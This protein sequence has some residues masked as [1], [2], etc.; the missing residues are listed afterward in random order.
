MEGLGC[1]K[2][3]HCPPQCF[4]NVPFREILKTPQTLTRDGL[5]GNL[6]D[7]SPLKE[8]EIRRLSGPFQALSKSMGE[9]TTSG[10]EVDLRIGV[11]NFQPNQRLWVS[12]ALRM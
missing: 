10:L 7:I 5:G 11:F 3:V 9:N 4:C 12:E 1:F 6:P 2:R 8:D